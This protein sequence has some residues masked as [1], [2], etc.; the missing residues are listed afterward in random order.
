M[1]EE[2]TKKLA[3]WLANEKMNIDKLSKV[4]PV[5]AANYAQANLELLQ[6]FFL[7]PVNVRHVFIKL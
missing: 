3:H 2:T 4:N 7:A 1:N 6:N 5:Q